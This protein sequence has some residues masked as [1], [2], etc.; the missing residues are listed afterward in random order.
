MTL[1]EAV[2]SAIKDLREAQMRGIDRRHKEVLI[3]K[4]CFDLEQA[5]R[6]I[7]ESEPS[8]PRSTSGENPTD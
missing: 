8:N 2:D 5:R 6:M 1:I 7:D 4:A 3:W